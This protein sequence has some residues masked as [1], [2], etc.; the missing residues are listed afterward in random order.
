MAKLNKTFVFF[1]NNIFLKTGKPL[2]TNC[3]SKIGSV[4]RPKKRLTPVIIQ[5]MS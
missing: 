2:A 3:N 1:E 5:N 4:I